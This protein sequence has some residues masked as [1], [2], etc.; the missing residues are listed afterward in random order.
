MDY[1]SSL[2]STMKENDCV[3]VVVNWFSKMVVLYH[4]IRYC[5]ALL[6][7]SVSPLWETTDHHLRL[8]Q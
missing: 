5:Q 8:G 2:L 4:N 1:M 3:F 7:M 6:Q